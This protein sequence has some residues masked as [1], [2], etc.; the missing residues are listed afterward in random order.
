MT[1]WSRFDT[2]FT[3]VPWS[4]IR[5][6]IGHRQSAHYAIAHAEAGYTANVPASF[7][8]RRARCS[9]PTRMASRSRASTAGRCGSCSRQVLLEEREVAA[10]DR[11]SPHRRAGVLGALR[12]PQRRRPL[13]GTAVRVLDEGVATATAGAFRMCPRRRRGSERTNPLLR[14]TAANKNVIAARARLVL[15][16]AGEGGHVIRRRTPEFCSLVRGTFLRAL[17]GLARARA[18]VLAKPVAESGDARP[19]AGGDEDRVV[20]RQRARDPGWRPSS[21]ACASALA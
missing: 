6:R 8:R 19:L 13:E 14:I 3:G 12:L 20:A 18:Q 16:D 4:A 9:R 11:A 21:I 5:E 15:G 10:R 17:K 7:L 1:R 2:T